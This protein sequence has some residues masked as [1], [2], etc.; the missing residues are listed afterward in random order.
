MPDQQ[1]EEPSLAEA[2]I[3][4]RLKPADLIR[5]LAQAR[6]LPVARIPTRDAA[7]AI[8]DGLR[9]LGIES[10]IISNDDLFLETSAI[11]IRAL[12]CSD[13][14]LTAVATVGRAQISIG[15][16]EVTLL[17]A[18]RLLSNR[19]EVEER[20]R[21]GRKQTVDSRQLTADESVLDIYSKTGAMNWRIVAGGFDFSC[22]G[23]AKGVTT[24]QNF[25]ALVSFLLDRAPAAGFD[26]SYN[27]ARPVLEALW[28]V[29]QQ[30]RQ[31]Q[32]RRRGSGKFNSA[33]I[34][35]TDNEGQFSRYSRLRYCLRLRE[36]E[37]GR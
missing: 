23:S 22:L 17:V 35:T 12:E 20:S 7:A 11:R 36:L 30:I 37:H 1:P 28:P 2:A 32:L 14:L 3:L 26:D 34:T 27:R 16:N 18:G 6:P 29:E 24:L 8:A 10:V 31:N 9:G 15:W 5:I 13:D 21:H 25:A 33:T 19:V 4:L